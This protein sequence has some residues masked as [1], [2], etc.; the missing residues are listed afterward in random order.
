MWPGPSPRGSSS[1]APIIIV[2]K[3]ISSP[4]TGPSTD[5]GNFRWKVWTKATNPLIGKCT[6]PWMSHRN[7]PIR[8]QKNHQSPKLRT[9]NPT[10]PHPRKP[11]QEPLLGS[12]ALSNSLQLSAPSWEH[13]QPLLVLSRHTLDPPI[14]LF[15]KICCLMWFS[16]Q[17]M[18]R[19]NEE[20]GRE[21]QGRA[22]SSA[23][24]PSPG[25][26]L[27][28]PRRL[29]LRV[30][31]FLGSHVS[32]CP[33]IGTLSHCKAVCFLGFCVPGH[34][35]HLP[36]WAAGPSQHSLLYLTAME[37]LPL[38]RSGQFVFLT[39]HKRVTSRPVFLPL[40]AITASCF[41][42]S[43]LQLKIQNVSCAYSLLDSSDWIS[44]FGDLMSMNAYILRYVI[45]FLLF[46]IDL[47]S[48]LFFLSFSGGEL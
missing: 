43:C 42:G 27:P 25:A 45:L 26:A 31:R 33:S 48:F 28:L 22:L 46:Y 23:V 32:G 21:E 41:P 4:L 2:T 3:A 29:P 35:G 24:D 5:Y 34:P 8:T 40:F 1:Q 36:I 17:Q 16:H 37:N 12:H 14:N 9:W 38:R 19:N 7:T 10:N 30:V 11:P 47:L 13:K 44:V 20:K 18:S 6:S 39:F 15:H